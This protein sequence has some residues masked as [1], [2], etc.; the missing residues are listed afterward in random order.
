MRFLI[1]IFICATLSGC[2]CRVPIV[3]GGSTTDLSFILLENRTLTSLIV[4]CEHDDSSWQTKWQVSGRTP[5]QVINYGATPSGMALVDSAAPLPSLGF[6]I[7]KVRTDNAKGKTCGGGALFLVSAPMITQ[8]SS[9][10]DCEN[11]LIMEITGVRKDPNQLLMNFSVSA[12]SYSSYGL[13]RN[14]L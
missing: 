11:E 6:C 14:Y 10:R 8:C 3:A 13:P 12:F 7:V 5:E 9:R 1:L 4:E 2:A